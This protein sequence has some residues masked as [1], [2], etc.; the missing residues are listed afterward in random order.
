MVTVRDRVAHYYRHALAQ[1]ADLMPIAPLTHP[2]R[3]QIVTVS[4]R[5]Q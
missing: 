5:V 2:L 4:I 3:S 1:S